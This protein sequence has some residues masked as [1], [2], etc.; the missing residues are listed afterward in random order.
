AG[1]QTSVTQVTEQ[2]QAA[3]FK[4]RPLAIPV[5]AHSALLDPVL[6]A[7]EA[8]VRQVPLALPRC[9]VVSS[10][11][12]QVV[13]RELTDPIYWRQHL[14]NTVRFDLGIT[15]LHEQ[16]IGIFLEIGPKPTLLGMAEQSL[17]KESGRQ[18]DRGTS[19]PSLLLPSLREGHSDW[20]QLLTSLGILYGQGIQ[21]DWVAFD[22][23]YARR[24]VVLPTYPFQRQRYWLDGA[25]AKPATSLR[26]LIDKMTRLPVHQETVYETEFS[27]AALPFLADHRVYERLVSPAACQLAM[28]LNATAL[29]LHQEQ[30]LVL[31]DVILPQPLVLSEAA[32]IT[33]ART[34][35]A[36]FSQVVANH[37][38]AFKL[39][40]FEPG[41][42]TDELATHVT[43]SA[44]VAIGQPPARLDLAALRQ[45]CDQACAVA[46]LYQEAA[47]L[48]QIALGPSFRWLAEVWQG[49]IDH[50]HAVLA[51]LVAPDGLGSRSGH[52]LHPGL[53]DACFQAAIIAQAPGTVAETLLPFALEQFHLYQPAVGNIWWCYAIQVVRHQW[54]IQLVDEQ[55][56]LLAAIMG[57]QMRAA[58]PTA[59]QRADEWRQ[60]LY[61]V[62]WQAQAKQPLP[63]WEAIQGRT[64][65]ILADSAGMGAALADKLQ[66]QGD[67][68]LLVY[69]NEQTTATEETRN[70][71]Q[72]TDQHTYAINPADKTAYQALFA[73]LF[74]P[75]QP[76]P[77][78][79]VHLWSLDRSSHEIEVDKAGHDNASL[80]C[81]TVLHLTQS[82]LELALQP[83]RLWLVTRKAQAVQAGEPV[84]GVASA[85]LWGM[86]KV[87]CI[88]HPEL[89]CRLVD[90]DAN[91]LTADGLAEQ[92]TQLWAEL[93]TIEP[94]ERQE[95]H[96]ALR[97]GDRY[98]ARLIRHPH[99][100]TTEELGR[101]KPP[102]PGIQAEATYLVTGGLGGI[103]LE[104][105]D[106][107]A[108]QG[109]RQLVLMGRG[110]PTP[111]AQ[112]RLDRLNAQGVQTTVAQ[113]DVSDF[114]QV[115]S[116]ITQIPAEHPLRGI[117]H[118]AGVLAD[119]ALRQLQVADFAH[120]FAA[121]VTG[122]WHLHRLTQQ[123]PL[124][125][126]VL[127]SSV[128]ALFGNLGQANYAAASAFLD[129]FAHY[130]QAQ[131][132][133]GV[134]INWG[135]WA[136]VGVVADL[137]RSH[138]RQLAAQG[139]G[140]I[141][142]AQ[143]MAA[144][145]YLLKQ[146]AAQIGVAPIQWPTFLANRTAASPFYAEFSQAATEPALDRTMS[147]LRLDQ[148]LATATAAERAPLLLNA[149]RAIIARVLGMR[150]LAQIDPH[151]SLLQMGLDSLMAIELRNQV[152]REMPMVNIPITTFI[153]ASV[154][155]IT[156][157]IEEQYI[158][159]QIAQATAPL[160]EAAP[161]ATDTEEVETLIL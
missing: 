82:L 54:N 26:P 88:E 152:S 74:P 45:A 120:V 18:G 153:D 13:T 115:A 52:L 138:Q 44:G 69:A 114:A 129:A 40:S 146:P 8:A 51:R 39:I 144:L 137:V 134:S 62:K 7:F 118:A 139:Y 160:V 31:E 28:V 149:L 94:E 5:A 63:Q 92:A 98:V 124:D 47:T 99:P 102:V 33:G 135:A 113:V 123:R 119:G 128:T 43:G 80:S 79:V 109:A 2:L 154:E 104:V 29:T 60:W 50:Q 71:Y 10:M 4:T 64:W 142:P 81:S 100:A 41:S 17:D 96:V 148:Q 24:K 77:Y 141:L 131:G 38:Q 127:F 110:Q 49:Q 140:A 65:L 161:Q 46:T 151:R 27:V 97:N 56:N 156:A 16:G 133:P 130:R 78:G 143:G 53:L 155:Q 12:G 159:T 36:L 59:V 145:A 15:T 91:D 103:G 121:K 101:G 126:F 32:G 87:I 158:H 42:E 67:L 11:T 76:K 89:H 147:A 55:G 57:F 66:H 6:D 90:L 108:K 37:K 117:F 111:A 30:A 150:D 23:D 122:S 75:D 70:H 58:A 22:R 112:A 61:E 9:G 3:G 84:E 125:F 73:A 83:T 136:E 106:W 14:R 72:H 105:A 86:G 132:L 68:P 85:P 19:V 25:K 116:V 34:V 35:Q 93:T 157:I 1:G 95:D 107:L 48:R 21:I 20:Q